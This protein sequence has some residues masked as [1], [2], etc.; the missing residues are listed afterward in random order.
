MYTFG[1]RIRQICLRGLQVGRFSVLCNGT[2]WGDGPQGYRYCVDCCMRQMDLHDFS[3][4]KDSAAVPLWEGFS[5]D[6]FRCTVRKRLFSAWGRKRQGDTDW[7][8]GKVVE[9]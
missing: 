8:P 6:T 9:A 5:S 7:G 3:R 1:G 4:V 2:L